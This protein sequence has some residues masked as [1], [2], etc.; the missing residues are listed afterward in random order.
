MSRARNGWV[1]PVSLLLALLLGLVPLPGALP[2]LRPYWLA[3][4]LA[5]WLLETPDRVGLGTAFVLGLLADLAFGGLL[6]EQSLRLVVLA[7]ILERFRA[8]LR[9]FPVSQQALTGAA[10]PAAFYAHRELTREEAFPITPGEATVD[11]AD[12]QGQHLAN[13]LRGV[14]SLRL[15]GRD[16][17]LAGLPLQ[18]LEL[19]LDIAPRGRG[20]R[21]YLDTAEQL[22]AEGEPRYRV[23]GDLLTGEGTVL[24]WRL[25]DRDSAGGVPAY[26]FKMT[27][28]QVWADFGNA[29]SATLS[30]HI[31]DL[32]RS[33][34]LTERDNRFIA[35]K[36][37]FPEARQRIGLNPTLL[38]WLIS[39]EHRLFHQLWH[40]TRDQWHKLSE[41]KREA[42]RGI[43]VKVVALGTGQALDVGRRGDADVVFVHDAAAEQKFV[44][45]GHGIEHRKVMYND[46]VLVGPKVIG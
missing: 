35:H 5:Y 27:L 36:Q 20:L 43:D 45:E 11:L 41:E 14:W 40:A 6:G 8:R 46:F 22:R 26:E 1:L 30:G 23:L 15:E 31:L 12:T 32:D 44:D 33:L 4:V 42:L 38:A 29:G 39:P 10:V 7:F 9:F 18:G 28:D 3:L 13:T 37:L 2:A 17:G 24:Y 19:L 25:I 16:A 21:G 34:A